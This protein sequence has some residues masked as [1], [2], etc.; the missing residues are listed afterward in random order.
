MKGLPTKSAMTY[1][2]TYFATGKLNQPY[3]IFP[4]FWDGIWDVWQSNDG[5]GSY[6]RNFLRDLRVFSDSSKSDINFIL[7]N[8][9]VLVPSR[10]GEFGSAETSIT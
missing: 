6:W 10:S 5:T 3:D 4:N 1:D 2:K 9:G 7:K 8:D